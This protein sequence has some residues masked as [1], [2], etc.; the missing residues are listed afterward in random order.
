[1]NLKADKLNIKEQ[2]EA[3]EELIHRNAIIYCLTMNEP[4]DLERCYETLLGRHSDIRWYHAPKVLFEDYVD[5]K[6]EDAI[7][8]IASRRQHIVKPVIVTP[9][10]DIRQ[11]F[12]LNS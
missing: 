9:V 1:M 5:S 12:M 10:D 11:L 6:K 3:A 2:I 7:M 8:R 4:K